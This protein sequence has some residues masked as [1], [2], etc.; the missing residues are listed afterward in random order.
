LDTLVQ[1]L[2]ETDYPKRLNFCRFVREQIIL[3]Q[4]FLE[5]VL[6]SDEASF[7]N[8][9]GVNK[10][11]CHYYAQNNPRWIREGHFQTVYS[12]NAWCGILGNKII[13]PYCF[14][15]RLNGLVYLDFLQNILPI[16]LEEIDLH[17][18]QNMWFQ[19]DGAPPHFHRDMRRCLDTVYANKWIGRGSINPWPPRSPDMTPL[20]YF[21]WGTVKERVYQTP[22]NSR[23]DLEHRITLACRSIT[24]AMLMRVRGSFR[25]RI[26]ACERSGGQHFEHLLN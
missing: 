16:L 21:L 22:I 9:G 3:D 5:N 1:G 25:N 10:H 6:F 2:K 4:T 11:N 24:P 7:N 12:T 26:D 17:R 14:R 23:E 19:Q 8:N 18:R 20:D 15:E 13:G